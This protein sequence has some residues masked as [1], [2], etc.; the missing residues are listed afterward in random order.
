MQPKPI[1]SLQQGVEYNLG[2]YVMGIEQQIQQRLT[3][4]TTDEVMRALGDIY[5][6]VMA[7]HARVDTLDHVAAEL[8]IIH[9]RVFTPWYVRLYSWFRSFF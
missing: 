7:L 2:G 3:L 8:T 6:E 9:E 4:A 5:S 1:M